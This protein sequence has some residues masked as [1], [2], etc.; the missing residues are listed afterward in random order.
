MWCLML[1]MLLC[2]CLMRMMLRMVMSAR[3]LVVGLLMPIMCLL[4]PLMLIVRMLL[5]MGMPSHLLSLLDELLLLFPC[6]DDLDYA[7]DDEDDTGYQ[8]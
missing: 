3:R 8:E 4:V 5:I 6:P 2:M 1:G 7:D